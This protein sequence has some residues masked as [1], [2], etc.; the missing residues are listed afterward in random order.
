MPL[1]Q[2]Q[3]ITIR[4]IQCFLDSHLNEIRPVHHPGISARL[5]DED[6]PPEFKALPGYS[7]A[8]EESIS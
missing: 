8:G 6:Y 7:A 3:Q 1:N 2:L 4:G 5:D